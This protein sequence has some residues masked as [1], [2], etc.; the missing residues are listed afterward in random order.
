MGEWIDGAKGQGVGTGKQVDVLVDYKMGRC[1]QSSN[2]WL[3][4]IR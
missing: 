2:D 1:M 3:E 4:K